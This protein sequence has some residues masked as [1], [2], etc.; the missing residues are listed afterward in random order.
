MVIMQGA[1]NLPEDRFVNTFHFT[2]TTAGLSNADRANLIDAQLQKFYENA[3]VGGTHSIGQYISE[4]VLRAAEIRYYELADPEPRV[5]EIRPLTLPAAFAALGLPEELA[6][7]LSLN[8]APPVTGRRRGRLFLGPL[9]N[10]ADVLTDTTSTTP[11]RVSTPIRTDLKLAATELKANIDGIAGDF[12][13]VIRSVTPSPNY[14]PIVGGFVDNAFDVQRRRG[15]VTT[16]RT[17]WP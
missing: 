12:Q 11:T 6:V 15:P 8:G 5:P 7:V 3:P 10:S 1:T 17:L 9:I 16:A 4:F 13:W 2:D 14:V